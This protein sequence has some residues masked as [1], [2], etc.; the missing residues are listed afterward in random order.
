[1]NATRFTI[2]ID[3]PYAD[4][5]R[6]VVEAARRLQGEA[7][8]VPPTVNAPAPAV[9]STVIGGG[10]DESAERRRE[11]WRTTKRRQRAQMST[12]STVTARTNAR[13]SGHVRA[14]K[15]DKGG[16][17]GGLPL[18]QMP[19]S[20]ETDRKPEERLTSLSPMS[21]RTNQNVHHVRADKEDMSTS[22]GDATGMG[23]DGMTPGFRRFFNAY[24]PSEAS[25]Q[26]ARLWVRMGL[27]PQT[28]H[29]LAG[30]ELWKASERWKGGYV[31]NMREWLEDEKWKQ[32]PPAPKAAAAGKGGMVR[33]VWDENFGREA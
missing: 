14:D 26:C 11:Y 28:T 18:D 1:V 24:P 32:P 19:V 9:A 8:H 16:V 23:S 7:A 13:T 29:I 17:G 33:P 15:V 5:I 25:R 12:L 2:T 6:F 4:P 30:L 22:I 10:V 3:L 27:E 20:D 21:A 31:K